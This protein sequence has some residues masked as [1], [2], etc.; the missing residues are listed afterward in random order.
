VN[1][2]AKAVLVPGGS[3]TALLRAADGEEQAAAQ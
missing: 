1:A 2:A 3:V